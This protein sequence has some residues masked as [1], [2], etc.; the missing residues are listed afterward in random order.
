VVFGVRPR[1]P[2]APR[3]AAGCWG[4]V[5]VVDFGLL[6]PLL[7]RD[8]ARPVVVSAPRQRVLLATLLLGGGRVVSGDA[9][10]EMVWDG[11]PPAGA[12]G[13]LHSAIQRL[14][15]TLGPAG[16][17]LITTWPPGY[18]LAPGDGE[19][20]V[21]QFAV[22][23]ARGQA[24][25]GAGGW[26][27]AAGLLRQALGLWRGEALAD[28]PSQLLRAQ[29]VPPLEDQR[30]AALGA[31]IDADLQ[32]GRAGEVAAEL[33]QLTA[34]HP[35]RERFHAQ[36]MLS[37]YLDGRQGDALA[38]YLDIRQ[39]LATE[40]GVDPGPEL[41]RLHQRILAADP[42]LLPA[43]SG[44]ADPGTAASV[45]DAD[46]AAPEPVVPRQLP[47]ATRH[48]AGR[49]GALGV[50]A[51]LAAESGG[52]SRAVV[53]SA[54]EGTAGVGK[55][56][57]AVHF[58]H[59][60]ADRFPDGQLYVNLRGFDPAA[61]PMT[62]GEAI[63]IFLEALGVSAAQIPASLD[64][65]AGL[66]RSLLAGRQVLVLLDN[67]ADAGQVRPLLPAG[68]GCLV[69]V[70]SRSQLTG[71]IA[72][73]GAY[74]LTL[75]VLTDTE[76]RELL[77]RRLGP[78]RLAADAAAAGELIEL[79]ARLPLALAI[80]AARAA[81]QPGLP[82]ASLAADLRDA[83][84]RL[85]ALDA[86]H[87]AANVR[88]V[89][90]WSYRQL[91]A[92][93]ARVFRLLGLHPGPDISAPAT[94]SMAGLPLRQA[95]AAL[96][97]LARARLLTE[98]TPGRYSF[99]DLLRAYAAERAQAD[100]SE[101]ERGA[102]IHRMLDHYLH[103]AYPA[104]MLV[105]PSRRPVTPPAPRSGAEPEHLADKAQVMAWFEA[106]RRVLAGAV[107][108]APQ[109][110]LDSYAWYIS[111]PLARFLELRGPWH[112]WVIVERTALAATQRLGDRAAQAFA[113]WQL[114][115]AHA[116]LGDYQDSHAQLRHALGHLPG[117]G[118]PRRP[119]R[120]PAHAG[121]HGSVPGR[122]RR[123]AGSF[124]AGAG[125]VHRRG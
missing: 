28:V 85:D 83:G 49:A 63:Q 52:E 21:R 2:L 45:L 93:Q 120:R 20:D 48:F 117:T 8:G 124:P 42:T 19:F 111:W 34:A 30:L 105:H 64:A 67:A 44:Q 6:G 40:L 71:L 80:A 98:Q 119:G 50:L 37:L 9:L 26:A 12:R 38:A 76:A 46:G 59:Q 74:P 77:D 68:P 60:V 29:Q 23:A 97:E 1:D 123:G 125:A 92:T 18:A 27:Q 78:E 100:D 10:A 102:A 33:R 104:A 43:G 113:H 82:L 41:Q 47:L 118:R 115:Y 94:A 24:A 35:L 36:L 14:R 90:S 5:L 56:T 3:P 91:D 95:R 84:G 79:C 72:T 32:L 89:F 11:R 81:A 112:E 39:L 66:Y 54:I 58:A 108:Q 106:E 103:T 114:G 122:V 121:H 109:A 7:V 62:P 110:G 73:E 25:A 53:I 88:A 87:G 31:R 22:L 69:L 57:L 101:A 70:T 13:A 15:A 65:Q 75:D 55:T 96:A 16:A 107:A 116:R 86:G 4:R 61:P 99:H 51:G 17:A